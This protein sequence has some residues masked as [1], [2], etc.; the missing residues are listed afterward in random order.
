MYYSGKKGTYRYIF[1]LT[2]QMYI[3]NSLILNLF[4]LVQ[5][6][7]FVYCSKADS[8]LTKVDAEK[9]SDSQH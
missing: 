3:H 5:Y 8:E 4:F 9:I 1:L 7:S 6:V 2:L